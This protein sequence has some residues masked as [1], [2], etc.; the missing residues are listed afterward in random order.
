M[1]IHSYKQS[2][3]DPWLSMGSDEEKI[4][5]CRGVLAK[6]LRQMKEW[7]FLDYNYWVTPYGVKGS[8]PRR[9]AKE[10]GVECLISTNDELQ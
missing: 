3:S 4:A 7:G 1:L 10:L 5:Q 6:G 9:T 8:G 2:Y